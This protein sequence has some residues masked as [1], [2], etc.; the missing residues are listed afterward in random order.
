ME[1]SDV[2]WGQECGR[3]QHIRRHKVMIKDC[4]QDCKENRKRALFRGRRAYIVRH[5]QRIYPN[6]GRFPGIIIKTTEETVFF[7][8]AQVISLSR[9]SFNS[10]CFLSVPVPAI[11]SGMA[12]LFVLPF[13]SD[14]AAGMP[15]RH[16]GNGDFVDNT[17]IHSHDWRM[18]EGG[19]IPEVFSLRKCC[20]TLWIR[21]KEQVGIPP[22]INIWN[23]GYEATPSAT[24][25]CTRL[26]MAQDGPIKL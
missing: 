7:S 9:D 26:M 25:V 6:W 1:R 22:T 24:W 3:Q 11:C 21:L 23:V 17:F 2:A 13:N 10:R 14:A 20:G 18:A 12:P 16:Q 8:G 15:D 5:T 19:T 4:I